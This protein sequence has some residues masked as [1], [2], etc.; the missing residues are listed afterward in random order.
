[1]SIKIQKRS[2]GV[3]AISQII[4]NSID[5]IHGSLLIHYTYDNTKMSELARETTVAPHNIYSR[6]YCNFSIISVRSNRIKNKSDE[7]T[8]I[9]NRYILAIKI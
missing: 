7:N 2:T 4:V 3:T 6:L 1:M 8:M 5:Y 9:H